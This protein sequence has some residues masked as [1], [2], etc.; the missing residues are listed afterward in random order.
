MEEKNNG[1]NV[2]IKVENLKTYFWMKVPSG[3]WTG[4]IWRSS[5]ARRWAW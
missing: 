3:L 2:L 5:A 4:S 1:N